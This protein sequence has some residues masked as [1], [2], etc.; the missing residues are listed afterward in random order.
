MH[1]TRTERPAHAEALARAEPVRRL[2]GVTVL[3]VVIGILVTAALMVASFV[4][5]DR[6]EDRLLGQR[7]HEAATVAASSIN[8]LQGQMAAASVAAESDSDGARFRELMTPLV[9]T[10]RRFVSGSVWP[11]DAA[12]AQPSVIVGAPPALLTQPA[13]ARRAFFAATAGRTV[14]SIRDFLGG[15]PRRLGYAYAVPGSR[16]VA[17]VEASLP[18]DRHAR[19]ASDSAFS[20]LDYALYLGTHARPSHLLASSSGDALHGQ[21]TASEVVGFGDS[22]ILLVVSPRGEL[23]GALL[24]ALPWVLAALGILLTIVAAFLAERL[25]RRRERAE[26]L[27]KRLEEVADENAALYASQREIAQQLQRSLM[28]RSLPHFAW[29]ESA[30]RYEAGVAGTEVGGDWY[31]VLPI[32]D[33]RVVFS[34][35]DVCGRGLSAAVLMASLRYSIRAYALEHPDPARILDRLSAVMDTTADDQFATVICGSLDA[36]AGTLTVARAGHPDLLVVDDD[37]AHYLD[38]PLGPPVGVD[39]DWSYRAV[40]RA[41]PDDATLLAYTD[42]LVERRR[43]HLDVGLER[44]RVAAL[45]DLQLPELVAHLV[46]SLVV[47]GDDDVA[48]LG[49][50]WTG[51]RRAPRARVGASPAVAATAAEAA[52]RSITL[53]SRPEA[54]GTARGFVRDTLRAWHVDD[55]DQISELLIDELVSNVVCHVGTTMEIRARRAASSMRIEVQDSSTQLP[56]R[57]HPG[58]ADEHGRGIMF[59][60]LLSTDWGVD[61]HHDGKT[62]WFEVPVVAADGDGHARVVE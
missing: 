47:D 21:R 61:V 37:G 4:V 59:V 36:T 17:Y 11:L 58:D 15:T 52:I 34:V 42:G 33:D 22:Q 29:L 40:T 41:L 2:H 18:R 13:D 39:D 46:D 30:A 14:L 5:H 56:V 16:S 7:G 51:S 54:P 55:T 6:N 19:I 28:A 1:V 23:G 62:I 38:A 26:E 9:G 45:A 10:S 53:P 49:L 20:D 3:V 50:H 60:E 31:D 43:E 12:D 57:R 27:S 8:G 25:I 48:V 35:G 44:L 32:A 24:A